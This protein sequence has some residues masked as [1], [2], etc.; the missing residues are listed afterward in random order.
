[1]RLVLGIVVVAIIS[2]DCLSAKWRAE[3]ITPM[4]S[5]KEKMRK[6]LRRQQSKKPKEAS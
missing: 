4:D 3:G 2:M 5:I 1:M 6:L